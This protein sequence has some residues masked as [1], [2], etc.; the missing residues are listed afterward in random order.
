MS[1]DT[2]RYRLDTRRYGCEHSS[3][4]TCPARV[5]WADG[6]M[7]ASNAWD[8]DHNALIPLVVDWCLGE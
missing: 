3:H 5:S 7:R 4:S 8:D 6:R 1:S 2:M